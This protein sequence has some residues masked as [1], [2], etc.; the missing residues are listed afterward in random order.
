MAN[1][2]IIPSIPKTEIQNEQIA[3][4]ISC[5]K[6]IEKCQVDNVF[7][8]LV[9]ITLLATTY[10]GLGENRR[11]IRFLE[12]YDQFLSEVDLESKY[13]NPI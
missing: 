6:I 2:P 8:K 13:F 10:F 1:K 9:A 12:S 7:L 11:T 3:K 5:L 4:L